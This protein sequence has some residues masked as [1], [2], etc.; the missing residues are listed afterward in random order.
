[1]NSQTSA[2][3]V[4]IVGAGFSGLVAAWSLQRE[5]FEVTILEKSDHAGG[6][7]QTKS[8]AFGRIETAANGLLSSKL[9]EELFED[10]GVEIL[11]P[12]K[13]ARRRY[14]D[15]NR[16]VSRWPL[17]I[18]ETFRT[19]GKVVK[20]KKNPPQRLETLSA[21]AER[22]LGPA[23]ARKIVAPAMLGIFAA[24]SETLSANLVVGRFYDFTRLRNKRGRHRGTVSAPRGLGSFLRDLQAK[25]ESRGVKI[26]MS[27]DVSEGVG[28]ERLVSA[29]QQGSK[30]VL[31]A[32][33][34]DALRIMKALESRGVV[35]A[36][37][38]R[39][40]ALEAASPVPLFSITAFFK[41]RPSKT[42]FG[43]LFAQSEPEGVSDG[44]L[45][46]LQNSEIFESRA[47]EG[48]HSETWILG[49]AEHG[50]AFTKLSDADLI[51]KLLEKRERRLD[52][53]T[54]EAFIEA[55]VTR[56]PRAVPHYTTKL[57]D[58]REALHDA[59]DGIVLFGNY[60]GE[61]GLASIL[62][63]TKRLGAR[64]RSS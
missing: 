47:N 56:W 5:G 26:E 2:E 21:W 38:R 57:E 30:V 40:K 25:L 3:K 24:P 60:L 48:L 35:S 4:V 54:R 43:T 20:A 58:V 46:A 55:Q 34:W 64:V 18:L 32:P 13:T 14:L 17:T 51:E 42:G 59:R 15:V 62:E 23:M 45:G 1:M 28:L 6:L 52:A 33:A 12:K 29:L 22:V 63:S 49:G 61:L 8:H 16:E 37:D 36:G 11:T 39:L 50:E 9:V 7:L 19:I 27:T 41:S 53:H 31:A 10:C 44:I